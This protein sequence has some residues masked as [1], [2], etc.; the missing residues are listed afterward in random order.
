MNYEA[1]LIVG[2]P[3][4]LILLFIPLSGIRTSIRAAKA[5]R[6]A[7]LDAELAAAERNDTVQLETILAHR[8]RIRGISNWGIDVGLIA[9][10][11]GYAVIAPLA[12]V[13]AALVENIV[14]SF[15]G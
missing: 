1:G 11:L 4:G 7:A 3:V 13:G 14:D 2:V 15:T 9:K 12:W 6:L 10:V 5:E 8:D